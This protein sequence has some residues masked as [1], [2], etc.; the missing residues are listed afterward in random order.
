MIL[1]TRSNVAQQKM[2]VIR[3]VFGWLFCDTAELLASSAIE[4]GQYF[5]L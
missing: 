5:K 4:I 3:A 1:S 2:F